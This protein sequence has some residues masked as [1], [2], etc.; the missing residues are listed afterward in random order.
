MIG[1]VCLAKHYSSW[2]IGTWYK[3]KQLFPTVAFCERMRSSTLALIS[4]GRLWP[5]R[6]T[7]SRYQLALYHCRHR[8]ILYHTRRERGARRRNQFTMSSRECIQRENI[9]LLQSSKCPWSTRKVLVFTLIE[10]H[11][12]L[13]KGCLTLFF[14]Y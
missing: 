5:N 10:L 6:C 7:Y 3:C 4:L 14:H 2:P 11:T 13:S 1:S 12:L 8:H 9:P